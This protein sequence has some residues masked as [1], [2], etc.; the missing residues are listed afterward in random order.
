[1]LRGIGYVVA[2]RGDKDVSSQTAACL[3]FS[4]WAGRMLRRFAPCLPSAMRRLLHLERKTVSHFSW[5]CP[6][7]EPSGPGFRG[8]R[9]T[10]VRLSYALGDRLCQGFGRA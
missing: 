7:T 2:D 6:R 5:N 1:M 8:Q 9:K 4:G 3:A 10:S